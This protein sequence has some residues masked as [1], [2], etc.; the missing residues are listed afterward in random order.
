VSLDTELEEAIGESLR[1]HLAPQ[2]MPEPTA[3]VQERSRRNKL[4]MVG[5]GIVFAVGVAAIVA[6]LLVTVMPISRDRGAGS[7]IAAAAEFAFTGGAAKPGSSQFRSVV[8]SGDSDHTLTHEQSEQLLDRFVQ[9]R[10][11]TD[12]AQHQQ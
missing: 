10:Q 4:L 6:A 5:G 3:F 12:A 11:K 7:G 9:W 2:L 8:V 1:R